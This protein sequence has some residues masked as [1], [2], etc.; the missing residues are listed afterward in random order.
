MELNMSIS[1]AH[2]I[3]WNPGYD[4]MSSQWAP[5]QLTDTRKQH[6]MSVS[7]EHL[8]LYHTEGDVFLLWISVGKEALFHKF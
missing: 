2:A 4:K 7:V 8:Q 3:L 1:I 6:G 5:W